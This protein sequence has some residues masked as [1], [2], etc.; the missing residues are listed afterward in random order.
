MKVKIQFNTADAVED[1]IY[2]LSTP[3]NEMRD[4]HDIVYNM[5]RKWIKYG[6]YVTLEMDTDT[7]T[8]R[9]VEAEE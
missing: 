6:E 1:A 2:G 3:L 5:A 9:V 4:A 8:I 7:E